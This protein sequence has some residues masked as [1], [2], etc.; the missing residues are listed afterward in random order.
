MPLSQSSKRW[1]S[2]ACA[3]LA[4]G[5][6]AQAWVLENIVWNIPNPPMQINLTATQSKLGAAQPGFPLRDG[7]G[8]FDS[9]FVSAVNSW[10]RYLQDL[11]IQTSIGS[12]PNAP[13]P[14]DNLSDT[15][16]SSTTGGDS[17]GSTTLALTTI[18]YFPGQGGSPG[19][20][21]PTDITFNTAVS[22]N[23]YRGPLT[24]DNVVDLRR[25]ALHE[26]GHFI[27]LDHPDDH[28][29]VVNAIMNSHVSDTDQLTADDIAGGQHLYGA[30]NALPLGT[31]DFV[32]GRDLL[33][34]NS[35]TGQVAVWVMNGTNIVQN[36]IIGAASLDWQILGMG[37]FFGT[38]ETGILWSNSRTGQLSIWVMNGTATPDVVT[39]FAGG[40][41]V[42][43]TVQA[44]GDF[45]GSGRS[46]LIIH[47][48]QIG[49]TWM[50]TNQGSLNFSVSFLATVETSWKIAGVA[51]LVGTGTPQL[52]WQNTVTGQVSEWFFSNGSLVANPIINFTPARGWVIKGLADVNGHGRD[53]IVWQNS[54]SGA[55]SVWETDGTNVLSISNPGDP[56]PPSRPW[57]LSEISYLN[58]GGAG[59]I[60]WRNTSDGSVWI[61]NVNGSSFSTVRLALTPVTQWV[62]Q[63]TQPV[64]Q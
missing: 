21:A 1:C 28:G 36:S 61:W 34:R 24:F 47:D 45:H 11:Q 20:F 37:D 14:N 8:S 29:Q 51:N 60:I 16:F 2:V 5:G 55:V 41:G 54:N 22:W 3:F 9:V 48:S 19:T 35:S 12:N 53:D 27:G 43:G 58:G 7:S 32:L 42:T 23:S 57:Q 30:R 6:I 39:F 33:W 26:L 13:D 40:T 64:S 10:N 25:V 49:A 50:L 56:S 15:G 46:D 59:Q 62:L 18:F 17:L 38:D 4:L 63:T 52:V 44:I 31:L